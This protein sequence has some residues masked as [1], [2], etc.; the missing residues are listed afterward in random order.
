MNQDFLLCFNFFRETFFLPKCFDIISDKQ[1]I[2]TIQDAYDLNAED[3]FQDMAHNLEAKHYGTKTSK[4]ISGRFEIGSQYRNEHSHF[5]IS[6]VGLI[7]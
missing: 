7:P 3:R 5:V 2:P 1:I 6:I 4:T